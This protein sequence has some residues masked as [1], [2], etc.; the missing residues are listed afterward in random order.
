MKK[1]LGL[2]V[3]IVPC[4]L[5]VAA[6][7]AGTADAVK[8]RHDNFHKLGGDFKA[9]ADQLKA[10]APDLTLIKAKAADAKTLANAMGSWF[11]VGSGPESGEKTE[12]KA[13]IWSDAAGFAAKR[14]AFQAEAT[15]LAA[16]SDL[17]AIK[18]QFKATGEACKACHMTYRAR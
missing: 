18:L 9:I 4:L 5:A 13:E 6:V 15:K 16:S 1:K 12:A 8:A 10:D 2:M 11:P 7:G 17:E 3:V 14:Q